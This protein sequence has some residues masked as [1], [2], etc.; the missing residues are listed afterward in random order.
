MSRTFAFAMGL[1]LGLPAAAQFETQFDGSPDHPAIDYS[2]PYSQDLV[3]ELNRRIAAGAVTPTFDEHNGYLRFVLNALNISIESQ[4]VVFSK[5][6]VQAR[7]ISPANPRTLFFNDSIVVGLVHGGFLEVA[8]QD[9]TKGTVFYTLDQGALA[10]KDRVFK[11]G[12]GPLFR[13][14]DSCLECHISHAT[15]GV[16]GMLI[17][18]A[19]P[20]PNGTPLRQLGNY[21]TD[22]RSPFE[23]RWGGWYV[24]GASKSVSHLGNITLSKGQASSS[25]P[26]GRV[27]P[28]LASEFDTAAYLSPYSDI[29]ALMVFD[30]Q[31]RMMNLLTRVGW[32][33][34]YAAHAE[35]TARTVQLRESVN[36]LVDYML[37]LDEAK[38][39]GNISGTSGFAEEFAIRGP[40]D[41]KGRS[42]RQL[43]LKRRLMRYP[44]SYMIYTPAFDGLPSEVKTAIYMRMWKILSGQ[45]S[46][47]KYKRLSLA[48]RQAV[49]DILI[50]TKRDLAG[51]LGPVTR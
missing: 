25:V 49:A 21:I 20:D 15:L 44:C 31:M 24:T 23:E 51:L 35:Q 4:V 6:S 3:S 9:P 30:H 29:A 14:D 43:D 32:E 26:T 41:S 16:P 33:A 28:S 27:L 42:L 8:A 40:Q 1:L 12:N 47:E 7:R 17:R 11:L 37:F 45:V 48:D 10:Y 13:R 2:S 5:T 36:E 46:G 38:F 34:R 22:H 18:S 19:I 39:Q 50:D